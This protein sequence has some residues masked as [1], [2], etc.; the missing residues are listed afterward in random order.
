MERKETS[1]RGNTGERLLS[2]T[3]GADVSACTL[4]SPQTNRRDPRPRSHKIFSQATEIGNS[5]IIIND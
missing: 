3:G 4:E 5:T 2:N 1:G